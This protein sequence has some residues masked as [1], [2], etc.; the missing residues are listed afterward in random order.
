MSKVKAFFQDGKKEEE[1]LEAVQICIDSGGKKLVLDGLFNAKGEC[2]DIF[3]DDIFK[4][5]QELSLVGISDLPLTVRFLK[6]LEMLDLSYSSRFPEFQILQQLSKLK[7][8]NLDYSAINQISRLEERAKG[9]KGESSIGEIGARLVVNELFDC[10]KQLTDLK[11]IG[12]VSLD[13]DCLS[14]DILSAK[15]KENQQTVDVRT[16][17][18]IDLVNDFDDIDDVE[19]KSIGA[20]Q[21]SNSLPPLLEKKIREFFSADKRRADL[22]IER[23]QE[24]IERGKK[25]L[26][27]DGAFNAKG[28]CPDIFNDSLFGSLKELSLQGIKE[29]P[30]SIRYLKELEGLDLSYS[31]IVN[32]P[33]QIKR[34]AN[35]SYLNLASSGVTQKEALIKFGKEYCGLYRSNEFYLEKGSEFAAKS[36][37]EGLIPLKNLKQVN[38]VT[39]DVVNCHSADLLTEDLRSGGRGDIIIL[40]L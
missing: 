16:H 23:V 24:Y 22:F 4:G 39:G 14:G 26:V 32:C 31:S 40:R 2:P 9:I 33:T 7:V 12:M 21:E 5:L 8:L 35:L 19:S 6:K 27:L 34:L 28:E 3:K 18:E 1:F 36:W 38:M 10:L 20:Q 25:E 17:D 15:F 30:P 13:R 11:E 37:S 29:L